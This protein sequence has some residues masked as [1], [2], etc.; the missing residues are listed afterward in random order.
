MFKL[1]KVLA[2]T[3]TTN[4]VTMQVNSRSGNDKNKSTH[5][6]DLKW[7][8]TPNILF[9]SC[10]A[11]HR[12]HTINSN[13][14]LF[15]LPILATQIDTIVFLTTKWV[16]GK[17]RGHTMSRQNHKDTSTHT[18]QMIHVHVVVVGE[19]LQ[20]LFIPRRLGKL[21]LLV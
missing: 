13:W 6:N 14:F 8:R 18:R 9:H 20:P 5:I 12:Y 11:E 10:G 15:I 21:V 1:T 3:R 19:P 2:D 4:T 7:A 16:T 17:C